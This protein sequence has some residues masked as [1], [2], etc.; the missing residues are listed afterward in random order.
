MAMVLSHFL[1]LKALSY[2]QRTKGNEHTEY[3]RHMA[4]SKKVIRN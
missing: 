3:L 2:Y 1:W 4:K